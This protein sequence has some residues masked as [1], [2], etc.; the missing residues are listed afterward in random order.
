MLLKM[1][2]LKDGT[3]SEQSRRKNNS[4]KIIINSNLSSTHA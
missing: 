3:T 4:H 2:L 1:E